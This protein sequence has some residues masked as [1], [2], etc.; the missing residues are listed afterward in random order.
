MQSFITKAHFSSILC[1]NLL[2]ILPIIYTTMI[3][4]TFAIYKLACGIYTNYHW[5]SIAAFFFVG[6]FLR[7]YSL[8]LK[9][10]LVLISF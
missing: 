10:E 2:L 7:L 9:K 1:I 8:R 4:L 3:D 6:N 5:H